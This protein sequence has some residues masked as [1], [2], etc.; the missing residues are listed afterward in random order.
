M[1]ARRGERAALLTHCGREIEM[2]HAHVTALSQWDSRIL[3]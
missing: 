1:K 3:S 2:L